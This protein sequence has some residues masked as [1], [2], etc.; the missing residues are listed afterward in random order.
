ML[1][2]KNKTIDDFRSENKDHLEAVVGNHK[3]ILTKEV[4]NAQHFAVYEVAWGDEELPDVNRRYK[5]EAF[6]LKGYFNNL[7]SAIDY[8]E[9]IESGGVITKRD[10]ITFGEY[11]LSE[12]REKMIR[13][14]HGVNSIDLPYEEYLRNVYHSDIANWKY[15]QNLDQ[16]D[17]EEYPMRIFKM[18]MRQINAECH[19]SIYRKAVG[20]EGGQTVYSFHVDHHNCIEVGINP[21]KGPGRSDQESISG[22]LQLLEYISSIDSRIFN[23]DMDGVFR[24]KSNNHWRE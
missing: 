11:L 22:F 12:E 15:N 24:K 5:V 4:L 16:S 13:M 23:E 21:D 19:G 8:A 1:V 7:K 9:L 17:S 3:H 2:Q 20:K 14:T 18:V 10:L 6:I